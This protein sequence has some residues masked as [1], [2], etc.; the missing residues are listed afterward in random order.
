MM[1]SRHPARSNINGA[2]LISIALVASWHA[3]LA[4]VTFEGRVLSAQNEP[5]RN[6]KIWVQ[7]EPYREDK[8]FLSTHTNS[9]GRFSLT[10]LPSGKYSISIVRIDGVDDFS[11]SQIQTRAGDIWQV[12]YSIRRRTTTIG[13]QGS[14][15]PR[16]F[17]YLGSRTKLLAGGNWTETTNGLPQSV[18]ECVEL[19][20]H[21][22]IVART[23]VLLC[24]KHRIPLVT[25]R[26]YRMRELT[27]IHTWGLR[28]QREKC[29]PNYIPH[30]QSLKRDK[31]Y[32]IPTMIT[33]CPKCEDATWLTEE[34]ARRNLN[35]E[36]A[37]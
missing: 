30:D 1:R 13:N 11:A 5:L 15:K 25:Q 22:T 3:A 26:G 28:L 6:V 31:D 20:S 4:Q 27:L 33:Y 9:N 2:L 21:P 16:R 36:Y 29:N 10:N 17:E 12:D 34:E 35:G 24:A 32:T 8:D 23:G 7:R 19:R 37:Q 14:K 18:R